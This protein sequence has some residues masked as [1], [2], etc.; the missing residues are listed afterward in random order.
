MGKGT[1]NDTVEDVLMEKTENTIESQ[2]IVQQQQH[3]SV[4]RVMSDERVDHSSDID[5]TDSQDEHHYD[6]LFFC[7]AV[8][9]F[10]CQNM[11]WTST[12]VTADVPS[13]FMN[14]HKHIS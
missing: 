12:K 14:K 3:E 13:L 10:L 7:Y 11:L 9:R 1:I 6:E 4:L 2:E 5:I 8:S